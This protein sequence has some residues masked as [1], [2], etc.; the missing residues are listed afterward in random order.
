MKEA[1]RAP[2]RA[3]ERDGL[4]GHKGQNTMSHLLQENVL[5]LISFP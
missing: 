5:T 4:L 3:E 1:E 2:G